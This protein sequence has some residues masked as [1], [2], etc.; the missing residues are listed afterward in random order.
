MRASVIVLA[1]LA[2][3]RPAAAE[4]VHLYAAGSLPAAQSMDGMS[5]K[6]APISS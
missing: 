2:M 6:A 1:M 5:R 3:T 4:T